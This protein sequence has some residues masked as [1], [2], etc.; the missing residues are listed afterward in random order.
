[1]IRAYDPVLKP[2]HLTYPQYLAMLVLWEEDGL[3][4]KRLGERLELDSATLTPLL[5]RLEH[6]GLVERR[7]DE[8]DE[9]VVRV[10]LTPKGDALREKTRKFPDELPCRWGFDLIA[11]ARRSAHH[12]AARPAEPAHARH[13]RGLKA[14]T[15]AVKPV[16]SL[17]TECYDPPRYKFRPGR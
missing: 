17:Q 9:R 16:D 12:Q 15:A 14:L 5:K 6:Q 8:V 13:R 11:S 7:R 2:L 3:A 1:M 4:V 10:T